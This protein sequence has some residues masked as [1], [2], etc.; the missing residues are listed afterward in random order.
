MP[1]DMALDSARNATAYTSQREIDLLRQ[2]GISHAIIS[3]GG[4]VQTLGTKPDGSAWQVAVQY[5]DQSDEYAII[6][7]LEDEA[8]VTSGSYQRYF[9]Q[10]GVR[11]HHIIDPATGAP[12]ESG[13][14]SVTIVCKD[15]TTADGLSTA[16]FIMGLEKGTDFWRQHNELF[17]AV[18]I[19]EEGDI[20]VTEGLADRC[21]QTE[22][23]PYTVL[24]LAE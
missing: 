22:G 15:G 14:S 13:L 8:A 16:L 7:Q 12:A 2:T 20:F 19:T 1:M 4:N 3:L 23:H 10:D 11:Y 21:I 24:P 17:D 5:M 6:L 18:F 9:E